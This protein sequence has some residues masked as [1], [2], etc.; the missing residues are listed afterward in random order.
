MQVV[1]VYSN[2][3]ILAHLDSV[4]AS[5]N[6]AGSNVLSE[7]LRFIVNETLQGRGEDLKEYTIGVNA[8]KRDAGFNPQTDS[9]VRIHAGRLRR[10][11]KEYYYEVGANDLII[12]SIPKGSYQPVF[13]PRTAETTSGSFKRAGEV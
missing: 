6:I 7:F 10:A 11:L 8:L 13:G 12:I 5:P 9:I 3:Q 2:E 4:L 1:N